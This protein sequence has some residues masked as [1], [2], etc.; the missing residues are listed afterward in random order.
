MNY[1]PNFLLLIDDGHGPKASLH[2]V[3]EVKGYR[4][5]DANDAEIDLIWEKFSA[6]SKRLQRIMGGTKDTESERS[7]A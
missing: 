3:L 6:G 2:L 1:V 4:Y 7:Q 5:L